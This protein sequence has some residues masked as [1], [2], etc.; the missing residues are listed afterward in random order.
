M[1]DRHPFIVGLGGAL[2][3]GSGN[4]IAL[5]V[6]L[7]AAQAAGAETDIIAGPDLD[8]PF[9]TL[10]APERTEKASR[11]VSLLRRADG[12]LIATPSYHGGMS[13]VIKNALDY[14]EDMR[15]DD[16]P[17]FDGRAVGCIVCA[18]G[19]QGVGTALAGMRSMVHALR[20]WP[21]P[22][23]AGINVADRPFDGD[24]G[25]ADATVS[26]Q[27]HRVASQVVEFA[28]MMIATESMNRAPQAFARA[29]AG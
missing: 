12:I 8:L 27:L 13:G 16:R 24:G 14:T 18:G 10:A 7:K 3:H 26:Q 4:E 6:A 15:D 17:Y 25:C 2:H 5:R 9:Y 21:T 20:G 28:N 11:L 19:W 1:S 29:V 23:A 22:F